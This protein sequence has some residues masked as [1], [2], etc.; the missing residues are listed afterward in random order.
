METERKPALFQE[1][2][3]T[4]QLLLLTLPYVGKG[5]ALAQPKPHGKKQEKSCGHAQ[6]SLFMKL[7]SGKLKLMGVNGNSLGG[8][9]SV[10]RCGLLLSCFP[11][12]GLPEPNFGKYDR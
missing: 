8:S 11:S 3:W 12:I 6:T 5:R 10:Y 7:K 1:K 4:A 9:A 2:T